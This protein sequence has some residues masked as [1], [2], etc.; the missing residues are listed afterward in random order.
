MFVV[1][2]ILRRQ[3]MN[4]AQSRMLTKQKVS[5]SDLQRVLN[6]E[7]QRVLSHVVHN[8]SVVV[9]TVLHD[10]LGFG[11]IRTERTLTHILELF[12]SIERGYVNEKELEKIL[13]EEIN[14]EI[15]SL[16]HI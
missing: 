10:K 2:I 12:D 16:I 8:Y 9:A 7:Q 15:L 14:V 3:K 11:K 4:R 1:L 5:P 6:S 13:L